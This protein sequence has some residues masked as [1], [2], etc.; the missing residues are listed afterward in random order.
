VSFVIPCG[1]SVGVV[2]PTG[3]G[4][5]TMVDVVLGL[6]TPTSGR[7]LVDGHDIREALAAWQAQIGYVPQEVALVDD[8]LRRNVAFGIHDDEID[9]GRVRAAVE[10]ARLAALVSTWPDGFATRIGERGVRLSGGERQRLAIARALYRQP[11]V[12]VFDEATS[13][14][15]PQTER[16]VTD[17]IDAVRGTTTVIVIAHRLT[18]VRECDRILLL[19]GGRL[20][21]QGRYGELLKS[22][23]L[24]RALA[25]AGAA[26]S[27]R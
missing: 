13:A 6:L 3:A 5:S 24:F 14:L 12:L 23:A 9:D 20:V 2:G 1:T 18:T 27:E 17:A 8:S 7:V 10:D 4:K 15:D 19:D 25:T 26:V 16:E 11:Q 21:A 22:S